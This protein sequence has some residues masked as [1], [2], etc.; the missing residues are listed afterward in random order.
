M[1]IN[2]FNALS[3]GK[4]IGEAVEA[5]ATHLVEDAKPI[6]AYAEKFATRAVPTLAKVLEHQFEEAVKAGKILQADS[7]EFFALEKEAETLAPLAA[8]LSADAGAA[9]AAIQKIVK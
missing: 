3:A 2:A 7:D 6:V 4:K 9:M 5:G 8:K 1:A